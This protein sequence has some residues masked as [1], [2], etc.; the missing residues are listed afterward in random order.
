[1]MKVVV[2]NQFIKNFYFLLY[3][4]LINKYVVFYIVID[5]KRRKKLYGKFDSYFGDYLIFLNMY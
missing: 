5:K 3:F 1:M 2:M 4:F